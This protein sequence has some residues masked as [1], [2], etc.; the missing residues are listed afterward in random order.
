MTGWPPFT[1][2]TAILS[3]ATGLTRQKTLMLPFKVCTAITLSLPY[4]TL[5]MAASQ[6]RCLH[7]TVENLR[8]M[9]HR[10][11]LF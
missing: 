5:E 8:E 7:I 3:A 4:D 6:G 10:L 9:M 2:S 11:P 1:V